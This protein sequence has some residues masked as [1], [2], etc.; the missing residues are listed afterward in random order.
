MNFVNNALSPA[1]KGKI[2]LREEFPLY[3]KK[4][5]IDKSVDGMFNYWWSAESKLNEDVLKIVDEFRHKGIRCYLASDQ[6]KIEL[7]ILWGA[8]D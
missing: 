5:N 4:W 2:D 6:E 1:M 8:W 3:L 7:P